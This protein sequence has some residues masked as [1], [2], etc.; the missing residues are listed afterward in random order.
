MK[1]SGYHV[2]AHEEPLSRKLSLSAKAKCGP[3][4][5]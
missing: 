2:I 4:A 5:A 1:L 3:I